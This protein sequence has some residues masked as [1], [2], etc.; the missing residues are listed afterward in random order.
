MP[1]DDLLAEE[2]LDGVEVDAEGLVDGQDSGGEV[3]LVGAKVGRLLE[4]SMT[5]VDQLAR[6][7]AKS[8]TGCSWSQLGDADRC[9]QLWDVAGPR[10]HPS[11]QG[12]Q[13]TPSQENQ[14]PRPWRQQSGFA[15]IDLGHG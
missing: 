15:H 8:G 14:S 4:V 9:G 13:N 10:L 3:A 12:K 1:P 7:S 5:G 11:Q 2:V 6:S